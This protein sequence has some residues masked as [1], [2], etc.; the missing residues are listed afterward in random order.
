MELFFF[1]L[2][3]KCMNKDEF[4][5]AIT[6][7]TL[8]LISVVWKAEVN[9]RLSALNAPI[10]IPTHV[11]DS[12]YTYSDWMTSSKKSKYFKKPLSQKRTHK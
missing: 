7:I 3:L 10:D 6:L 2:V 4:Y 9:Y 1:K 11:L 8:L 5:A 12:N